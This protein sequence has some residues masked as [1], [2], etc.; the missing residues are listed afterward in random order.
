MICKNCLQENNPQAT[1]CTKCAKRLDEEAIKSDPNDYEKHLFRIAVVFFSL[2]ILVLIYSFTVEYESY[3]D[4]LWMNSI[5][6]FLVL[7]FCV[8]YPKKWKR[9]FSVSRVNGL[10]LGKVAILMFFS[11]VVVS[12][13]VDFINS[14]GLEDVSYS[15]PFLFSPAPLLLSIISTAL[16]P[17]IFE[18]LAFRGII[19]RE[20]AHITS[21][22]NAILLSAILFT[23]IHFSAI[24]AL[25]IFPLGL[26]FGYLRAK[27]RTLWYGVIGHFV[28]NSV[29]VLLEFQ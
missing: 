13:L 25:W 10:L 2:L 8:V 3:T 21:L 23:V 27:H 9:L 14:I 17:A 22:R 16:F 19:L 29:I 11:A 24:S 18:E 7:I 1:F 12:F 15:A 20:L 5:F 28:Y 6:A 26:F 4:V